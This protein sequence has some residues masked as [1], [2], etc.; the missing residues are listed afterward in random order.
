M[1]PK[2]K[3]QID[4]LSIVYSNNLT[5]RQSNEILNTFKNCSLILQ[6]AINHLKPK[7][8]EYE[9]KEI[10]I[11]NK[12]APFNEFENTLDDFYFSQN[13]QARQY[14]ESQTK[15]Q[16]NQ[17]VCPDSHSSHSSSY[18]STPVFFFFC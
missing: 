1:L 5:P 4:E 7:N 2:L 8:F 10:V 15:S 13:S 14:F 12:N 6:N 11:A 16:F 9:N 18:S 17:R 3:S